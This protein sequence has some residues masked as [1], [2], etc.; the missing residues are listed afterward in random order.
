MSEE[1]TP[2][3]GNLFRALEQAEHVLQELAGPGPDVWIPL[4]TE[5]GMKLGLAHCNEKMRLMVAFGDAQIQ[6]L[7]HQFTEILAAAAQQLQELLEAVLAER[8][9]S[10]T[11][12]SEAMRAVE[13][14]LKNN[15]TET[16][17]E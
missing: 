11:T 8:V 4:K 7:V 6:L 12:M 2:S 1:T 14:F 17:S 13:E 16:R 9:K 15:T 3:R 5:E 10:R